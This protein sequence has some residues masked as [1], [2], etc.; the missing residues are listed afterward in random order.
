M[1]QKYIFV[2]SGFWGQPSH[3]KNAAVIC[4]PRGMPVK[5]NG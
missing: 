4:D 5:I 2:M 1:M 3:T